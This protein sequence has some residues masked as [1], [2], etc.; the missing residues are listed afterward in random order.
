MGHKKTERREFNMIMELSESAWEKI[1]D[2][3]KLRMLTRP[4][5]RVRLFKFK[6]LEKN[7]ERICWF[8]N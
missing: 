1:S 2:E 5:M 8:I 4:G 7:V 3:T 6:Q